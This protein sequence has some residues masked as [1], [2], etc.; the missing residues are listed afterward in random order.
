MLLRTELSTSFSVLSE[1]LAMT[2]ALCLL[3]CT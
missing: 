3:S 2:Q 1:A